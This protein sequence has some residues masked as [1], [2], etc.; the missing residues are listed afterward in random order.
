MQ[1]NDDTVDAFL[2]INLHQDER[3]QL[4]RLLEEPMEQLIDPP[5]T[6]HDP[7]DGSCALAPGLTLP[8]LGPDDIEVTVETSVGPGIPKEEIVENKTVRIES[9]ELP[10]QGEG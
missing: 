10:H 8:L 6:N 7:R 2:Q 3:E 1:V 5:M 4:E 9:V